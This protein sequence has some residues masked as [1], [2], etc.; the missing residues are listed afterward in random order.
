M[1]KIIL[2]SSTEANSLQEIVKVWPTWERYHGV[3]GKSLG[4]EAGQLWFCSIIIGKLF[5]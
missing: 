2:D 3:T 5:F 1:Q 4:I